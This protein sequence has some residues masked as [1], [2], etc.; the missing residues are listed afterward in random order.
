MKSKQ[1]IS[2]LT[3]FFSFFIVAE[4]YS[5]NWTKLVS[6][7]TQ[8]L[9]GISVP[10]EEVC[11][12]A[13][14]SGTI[15]KTTNSGA[16]WSSQT[17]ATTEN[18]QSILFT[19]VDT[20]FVVGDDA[21]AYKTTNGGT[22]WTPLNMPSLPSGIVFRNIYFINKNIGFIS[23]GIWSP[24]VYGGYIYKTTDGG[25]S[26]TQCLYS[27]AT[28]WGVFY[29]IKF[30]SDSVGYAAQ[31]HPDGLIYKT[32][33]AG[34][35]WNSV[36][37]TSLN[38]PGQLYFTSEMDGIYTSKSG[39]IYRTTNG[40]SEWTSSPIAT[41]NIYGVDFLNSTNGYI[42]GGNP[43]TDTAIIFK[44]TDA[45]VT[46]QE[47]YAPSG[48]S[49]LVLVNFYN[50][51]IGFSVG[52]NGTILKYLPSC[53]SNEKWIGLTSGTTQHLLGIS[54]PSEEVC[55]VAGN[56]GTILK[57][58]NSGATWS[59]QTIATTE[60]LQSILFTSVDTG[61]VVGDDAVAYKTTNG[62]TTWTP[63][64]MP[65]L[66]S[67]IVFRNIYFINKN[68][69]FISGGIWSPGVYGGY[70]YKTT[71]GGDSWTQCL[72]SPATAWGVFYSIKFT[73]DS[74]G[75]AAQAHPDG[76]IYKTTDAGNTWNSVTTTSLNSPGQLY[77]TSEMD[78]IYTSKSGNIYR[79]TNGGSEWTSSPIATN[80]IYGVDFLNSTNG[81][82]VGG[83][84]NT[85]TAI[86][87]KTTDAGVTWQEEYAPSG[88][89]RLVL[90]NFYNDKIGFSVGLNGTILKYI[91]CSISPISENNNTS[92]G[93]QLESLE[94]IAEVYPNPFTKQLTVNV[95]E[96]SS[97]KIYN[98]NGKEILS[99]NIP[100]GISEINTDNLESGIYI[101]L[102]S[103]G[104]SS[105]AKKL[106]KN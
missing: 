71:D 93:Q 19:S 26:W 76:L 3:I 54:A 37:T 79:T 85:D 10:S 68:I 48:S 12:V 46:W 13:G 49:R 35:T 28:A 32:T 38:S 51:K 75:Y 53:S 2:S 55:Y 56:S 105:V 83:N 97:L 9:L 80:N 34:N 60:N 92:I 17:I 14:N 70:I 18:L 20:G 78:G 61:F 24:G 25:D 30:T 6:G 21:V 82:I 40:G 81:Y 73:S 91:G 50:D 11:Y 23:G 94:T 39:N 67:G 31:A 29:S 96:Y 45:G 103:N 7:T 41:N 104:S 87:F 59:S 47:E 100:Q 63:L 58:T 62:G 16:T 101:I 15:L 36:T 52:L 44:T 65:S 99:K 4:I 69:G 57:T 8:H 43:N 42:V 102:I 22:T 1:I 66:P 27:P 33:D 5:Q 95:E 90:V 106:I 98:I 89:S 88:S 64:N 86:I 74:V 72:Y 84:P 77:F